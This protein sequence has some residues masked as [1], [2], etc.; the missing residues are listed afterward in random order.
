MIISNEISEYKM[1]EAGNMDILESY[2]WEIF[3]TLEVASWLCLLLFGVLRYVMDKRRISL[4][5]IL[6]FVVLIG[7]E[8]LLALLIYQKTG[9]ISDFQIVILI[10]VAY[11][12]TF[13]V[14]DFKKLDRWMRKRIGQWRGKQLLT[15]KDIY[16]MKRNKDP[17][18]IAKK[19]RI[20]SIIHTVIFLTVQTGLWIY[21]T[22]NFD[23]IVEFIQDLSWIGTED[24]TQTPYPNDVLYGLSLVWGIVFVVD[25]IYSWS[26][27]FFPSQN[28][29]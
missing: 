12:I 5:F 28:K 25:L 8:G 27:T 19:Y 24:A 7:L 16:I 26:Y 6:S 22:N 4:G 2:Q 13:G 21:G 15:D 20:S 18:Y 17:Q 3:I 10:F 29:D 11:A 23:E 1:K 14:S 9:I